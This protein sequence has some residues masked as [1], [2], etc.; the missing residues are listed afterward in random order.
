MYSEVTS[1]ISLQED[2]TNK[3][4]YVVAASFFACATIFIFTEDRELCHS[5]HFHLYTLKPLNQ[6][7]TCLSNDKKLFS[8][9]NCSRTWSGT[10]QRNNYLHIHNQGLWKEEQGFIFSCC[11]A[12][13]YLFNSKTDAAI[14][15]TE[16]TSLANHLLHFFLSSYFSILVLVTLIFLEICS[17]LLFA[18]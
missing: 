1:K 17:S 16:D 4:G 15:F 18:I 8:A 13:L 7:G 6:F 14:N 11:K 5:F 2:L 10:M 3:R 9:L 12:M